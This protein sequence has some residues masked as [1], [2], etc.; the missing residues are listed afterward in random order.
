ML[1][2]ISSDYSVAG[3]DL[4]PEMIELAK[5]KLLEADI[6]VGDMTS[7]NFGRTFDVVLCMYDSINHLS[8]WSQWQALFANADKH[9]AHG[10]IF[11][12]DFNTIERLKWLTDNPPFGREIGD[13]YMF[14]KIW[15]REGRFEWDIRV[16]EKQSDGHFILHKD[17]VQEVSFPVDQV[18]DEAAK[19]FPIEKIVD[20][21]NL[22]QSNPNWR[23]FVVCKKK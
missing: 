5:K 17:P 16:F 23:P 11:I 1:K 15:N 18:M 14:M 10:G 6:R 22:E 8:D 21:K 4:S 13:D 19:R 20:A 9:L 12:F 2:G 3:V 7:Y